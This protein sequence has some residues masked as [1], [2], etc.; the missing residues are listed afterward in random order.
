MHVVRSPGPSEDRE[1]SSPNSPADRARRFSQLVGSP[2][3]AAL[4]RHL[5]LRP[6]TREGLDTLAAQFARLPQDIH[7]CMTDLVAAGLVREADG[8]YVAET[9]SIWQ[10]QL[11]AFLAS[12]PRTTPEDSS[13]AAQHFRDLMGRDEK[14]L[15]VFESIRAA[16]K[17]EIAVLILGPT[18]SGKEVAARMI[19]ELGPRRNREMQ[20]LNCAALPDTLFESEM[21]GYEKGAFTGAATSK[22]GR[23]ELAH[24]STLF[25][26]EIADMSAM[27]QAKLLRVL[28]ERRVERLG[29]SRSIETDFRL[30][31]A[32]NRP[33]ESLVREGRF[34]EDL[35]YRINAFL[36]RLPSLRE[37]A[38]DIP[39]LAERFLRQYCV[40]HGLSPDDKVFAP[41]AM[42]R[43]VAHDWPGNIREL[44]NTV[45]RAALSAPGRLISA[46]DVQ[47]AS[48]GRPADETPPSGLSSLAA[49][50]RAHI[51]RV[52]EAVSWNKTEAAAVLE[53][54]RATLYR[55][56]ADYGLEPPRRGRTSS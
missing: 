14:M 9:S 29:S 6:G 13:P 42:E 1:R 48:L 53:I 17:S 8:G 54:G 36:I 22:P 46:A 27:G 41:D 49:A 2:L 34:R 39:L 23:V 43:L 10:P 37:R 56:I 21:F 40:S 20:A 33:L 52:L 38:T 24:R 19:H 31:C 12:P 30:I 28:Q 26:D 55:K 16:A 50:E 44:E 11:E 15:V 45:A 25:L 18:G 47:F 35:Y 3:R 4:L 32:T 7:N 5:H 51:L